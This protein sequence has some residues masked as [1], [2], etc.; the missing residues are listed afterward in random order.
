MPLVQCTLTAKTT[1]YHNSN[2]NEEIYRC[3]AISITSATT[4]TI[5]S[6]CPLIN[7]N[8]SYSYASA[9]SPTVRI[10]SNKSRVSG[11]IDSRKQQEVIAEIRDFEM[12][13]RIYSSRSSPTVYQPFNEN[14][15]QYNGV[16]RTQLSHK[17][18]YKSFKEPVTSY[19][20][21]SHLHEEQHDGIF[22]LEL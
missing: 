5:Y 17:G 4:R 11:N 20:T 14:L 12:Y 13:H 21:Q 2:E 1:K 8:M 3:T 7:P 15:N 22:H 19:R 18:L 9:R 6:I 16:W 10:P